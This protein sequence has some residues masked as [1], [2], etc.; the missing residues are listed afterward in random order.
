MVNIYSTNSIIVKCNRE[1]SPSHTS[2]LWY[3]YMSFK[4]KKDSTTKKN[5]LFEI[6]IQRKKTL[7]RLQ[8]ITKSRCYL[9]SKDSYIGINKTFKLDLDMKYSLLC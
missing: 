7:S 2:C 9:L 1:K 3:V 4:R 8:K 6:N 5:P